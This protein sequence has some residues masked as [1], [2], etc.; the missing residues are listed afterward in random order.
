[1]WVFS[2]VASHIADMMISSER[3]THTTTR[4][5]VNTIGKYQARFICF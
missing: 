4:K 5:I 1:M 2:M 3:F